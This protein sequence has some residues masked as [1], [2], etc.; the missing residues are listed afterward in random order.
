MRDEEDG[1]RPREARLKNDFGMPD[2]LVSFYL[3]DGDAS[4]RAR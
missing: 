3:D 1:I 4:D 2:A